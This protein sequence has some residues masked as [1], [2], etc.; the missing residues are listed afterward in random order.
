MPTLTVG[1]GGGFD[2]ASIQ[3]AVAAAGN[4]DVIDV[5]AGTYREQITVTGKDITIQGAGAGQTII[6]SPDAALLISSASDPNS[7]RPT[8][9]AVVTVTGNADVTISGVTVDGR[10][11]GSIPSTNYDFLDIYVL[12]SDAHIDGVAVTGARELDGSDPSQP[13]GNQRNHA[14]P[15]H[16]PRRRPWRQW[17]GIRLRSRIR[18]SAASR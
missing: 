10:D 8:K 1:T 5:A 6:E 3:D 11:Q 4:G 15:C 2:F 12:N 16:Q 17:S 14:H 7:S 18:P 9:Y 13:S